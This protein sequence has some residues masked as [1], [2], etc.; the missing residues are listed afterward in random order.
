M[1]VYQPAEDTELLAKHIPKNLRGKKVLDMG[2]GSGALAV[3]A[4]LADGDVLAVDINEAALEATKEAAGKLNIGVRKSD[5]FE[6]ITEKFDLILFNPPYVP[7]GEGD[8]HLSE[9]EHYALVSGPKGRDLIERFLKTFKKYLNPKGKVLMVIS[10]KNEIKERL[11]N[12]GWK[13]VDCVHFF[14][15]RLYLMGYQA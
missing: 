3:T 4:A 1:Q 11:E 5:L 9:E 13:E 7:E 6:S 14:F 10:S 2:C 12:S 8:E 15:E